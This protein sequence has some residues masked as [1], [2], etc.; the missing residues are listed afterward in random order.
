MSSYFCTFVSPLLNFDTGIINSKNSFKNLR[1]TMLIE[2]ET[3]NFN[4]KEL[5][6]PTKSV[7]DLSQVQPIARKEKSSLFLPSFVI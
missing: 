7:V 5:C 2:H 4:F 3:S 1:S 6:G